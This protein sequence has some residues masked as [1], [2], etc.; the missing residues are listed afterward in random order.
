MHKNKII[1][2]IVFKVG[3]KRELTMTVHSDDSNENVVIASA[4][5]ELRE[6]FGDKTVQRG[7][8]EVDGAEAVVFLDLAE[9]GLHELKVTA[10]VGREVI[11]K[12]ANIKVV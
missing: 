2:E 9:K 7:S 5:F 11:I 6:Q 4:E 8:C 1:D 10:Y 12:T 3:E